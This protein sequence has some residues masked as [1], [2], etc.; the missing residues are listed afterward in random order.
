MCNLLLYGSMCFDDKIKIKNFSVPTCVRLLCEP[1][2]DIY[3]FIKYRHI[4]EGD[5]DREKEKGR[6]TLNTR[7]HIYIYP[8]VL[9]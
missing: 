6:Q 7:L 9:I 4:R 3:M 1:L 5:G 2:L 8:V